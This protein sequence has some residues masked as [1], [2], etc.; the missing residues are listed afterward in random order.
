MVITF[1]RDVLGGPHPHQIVAPEGGNIWSSSWVAVTITGT[2]LTCLKSDSKSV[3]K[4]TWGSL[5]DISLKSN[6]HNCEF[7]NGNVNNSGTVRDTGTGPGVNPRS[8]GGLSFVRE[9]FSKFG[10][11][12]KI[13]KNF[14][15][16]SKCFYGFLTTTRLWVG[17]EGPHLG[18][19]T[20]EGR[21]SFSPGG[22]PSGAPLGTLLVFRK[23]FFQKKSFGST[24]V[25]R[26]GFRKST[27]PQIETHVKNGKF[28][29]RGLSREPNVLGENFSNEKV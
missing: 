29:S 9:G 23:F 20:L 22:P 11:R 21:R 12:M 24:H 8:R 15:K 4:Y 5:W 7:R 14:K 3:G 2:K 17:P 25:G 1:F 16:I 18:S 13:S 6:F 26:W 10:G 27:C 19:G 28:F